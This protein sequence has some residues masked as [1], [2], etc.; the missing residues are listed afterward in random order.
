M[1]TPGGKGFFLL[2][3]CELCTLGRAQGYLR[4]SM[5]RRAPQEGMGWELGSLAGLVT[6]LGLEE[7]VEGGG[8]VSGSSLRAQVGMETYEA[9]TCP[10]RRGFSHF[11]RP[12]TLSL[13]LGPGS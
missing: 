13:G 10:S 9:G 12:P 2:T 1:G 3:S 6:A 4:S 7:A 11:L 5:G 8:V